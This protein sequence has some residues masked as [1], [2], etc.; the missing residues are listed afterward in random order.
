M[1]RAYGLPYQGS[2]NGIVKFIID[3]IP[4]GK[5]KI[6]VD[7]FGGGGAVTHYAM[8]QDKYADY[9]LNDIQPGLTDFF[10]ECVNGEHT[11]DKH[12]KWISRE[13]FFKYKDYDWYIKLCWSFSNN[14]CGYMYSEEVEPWKKMLWMSRV[15]GD[16][17]LFEDIEINTDGSSKDI[18]ENK[19][20]YK[21]KY[22]RWYLKN[23]IKT[24][25][26]YI[27]QKQEV[28]EGI[29]KE[30]EQLREYLVNALKLSGLKQSE[31]NKYLGT[32]MS[33]HYFAKSQWQFP[34]REHYEKMQKIMPELNK[35]YDDILYLYK[36]M[37]TLRTLQNLGRLQSLESL[38]RLQRLQIL[39]ELKNKKDKLITLCQSYET[40][41]IPDNA[42]IYCDIPY[43]NTE[44]G[45]YC[46]FN[47]DKFYDWAEQQKNIYISE[48]TM[49]EDRFISIAEIKKP[50]LSSGQGTIKN[51]ATEK[52]WVPR[53]NI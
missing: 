33:K 2:K 21:D 39:Q 18:K 3:N 7:L 1:T 26:D 44:C 49:P 27:L 52:I 29:R 32:Q 4:S 48:Y 38:E 20:E 12:T 53:T 25:N 42:I 46:G 45:C 14:G 8:E 17:S 10:M 51:K 5:D 31:V 50:V 37:H 28:E 9:I 23:I 41:I 35:D 13:D 47:Y 36:L 24:D 30:S 40:V 34:T 16:F 22:I 11:I 6:L 43:N 19:E 15:I